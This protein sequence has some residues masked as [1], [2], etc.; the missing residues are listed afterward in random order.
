LNGKG[1]VLDD[2]EAIAVIAGLDRTLTYDKLSKAT[3]LIR[4]GAEFIATNG[5][6][7]FPMPFG[8]VPGA[9]AIIAA[10]ESATGI[11]PM[12]VGKPSSFMYHVA[13]ERM[14]S[15]PHQT[16]VIGDRL[17][18]D[19]AGAQELNCRSAL[20]LSGVTTEEMAK[21]WN[22]PPDRITS[23]LAHLLQEFLAHYRT[24]E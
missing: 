10:L 14:G 15:N 2:E 12:V 8:L 17:E 9:G 3:I 13:M 23:D 20:V 5:D 1:F 4:E 11:S 16:I 19:I 7:T 6:R 24:P 22:P 21:A 18:T